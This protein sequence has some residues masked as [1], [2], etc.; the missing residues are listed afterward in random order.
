MHVEAILRGFH[1]RHPGTSDRVFSAG[2]LDG[3]G[4]SYALLADAITPDTEVLELACGDGGLLAQLAHTHG[5]RVRL[6]GVDMSPEELEVARARLGDQA[7]LIE[8][9]AQALPLP[10]AAFDAVISHMALMLMLPI[11]PVFAELARVLR[12][13]GRL[14]FVVGRP[15]PKDPNKD[16]FFEQ[17][18][19]LR[20]AEQAIAYGDRRV[21]SP[22]GIG[23][24]LV[25]FEAIEIQDHVLTVEI[26]A[27]ALWSFLE[28]AYYPVE[29]LPGPQK[30]ELRAHLQDQRD[31]Y[32]PDG[33]LS[34]SFGLRQVTARRG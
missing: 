9:R 2:Q 20:P 34:W 19:R 23:E 24:L 25:G 1:A 33:V 30:A 29:I 6:T 17:L 32:A 22:E 10:D 12:P 27:D 28:L 21:R 5:D 16:R 31:R 15:G 3:G 14:A 8:A 4:T 7:R 26:P 11:E 18:H 13:G